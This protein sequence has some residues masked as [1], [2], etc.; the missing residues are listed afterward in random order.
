LDEAQLQPYDFVVKGDKRTYGDLTTPKELAKIAKYAA[1]IGPY[2]R[3]I[4]P[5]GTDKIIKPVTSLVQDAHAVNLKVHT[6]TFRKEA[7][8]LASDYN[9]NPEAEY[10]QFFRLGV[11]GVFSD[12]PDTAIK[13]RNRLFTKK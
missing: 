9:E 11:D 5:L 12:F 1:G 4:V 7:Q 6:W 13:V 3:L 2:K 10:E 8:Y